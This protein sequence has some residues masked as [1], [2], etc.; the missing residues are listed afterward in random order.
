VE[1]EK[2]EHPQLPEATQEEAQLQQVE[3]EKLELRLLV[4]EILEEAPQ[5]LPVEAMQGLPPL[6]VVVQLLDLLLRV[7]EAMQG[8]P[9]LVVVDQLPDLLLRVVEEMQE[10]PQLVVVVQLLDLLLPV[11]EEMQEL[12]LREAAAR[13][14]DLQPLVVEVQ[15]RVHLELEEQQEVAHQQ[16]VEALLGEEAVVHLP[17]LEV[18]APLVEEVA[19]QVEVHPL[20][21]VQ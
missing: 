19:H 9:P 12:L 16:E 11:E 10:L 3:G 20:D 17:P 7:V 1:G 15:H 6:V 4:E 5:P 8:L 14:P 2:R 13:L 21:V 18:E